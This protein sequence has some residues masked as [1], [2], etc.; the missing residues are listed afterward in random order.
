MAPNGKIYI[1]VTGRNP[2][3]RWRNGNGYVKSPRF[4]SAITKYG[5]DYIHHNI[6][7]DNLTSNEAY[8]LERFFIR[9]LGAN[10]E[11]IGYNVDN[12]GNFV[13]SH[14][15]ETCEKI[16][17]WHRG[18]PRLDETKAKI[19]KSRRNK[20]GGINHPLYGKHHSEETKRKI[21]KSNKGKCSGNKHYL[22]G[23]HPPMAT[24]KK[25]SSNHADVS[26]DKNPRASSVFMIDISTQTIIKEYNCIADAVK[27]LGINQSSISLCCQG[28]RKS[29]G[30]YIWKYKK[31]KLNEED[32]KL[33]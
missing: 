1:G 31:E 21:S 18:R 17:M 19:S 4:Y 14:S 25:M 16:A 32:K 20:Y 26:G 11:D 22:Y 12:G 7:M 9:C 5:W 10:N 23:K 33:G 27:E 24:R 30:G 3:D 6:L 29:A 2:K 15:K 28:K 8:N 13:G